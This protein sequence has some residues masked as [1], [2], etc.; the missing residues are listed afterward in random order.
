LVVRIIRVL[1]LF[2]AVLLLAR[3]ARAEHR[4]DDNVQQAR[5][6]F[7]AG[8]RAYAD[9]DYEQALAEFQAGYDLEPRAGFLLNMGHAARKMGK[10]RKARGYYK[11]FLL[12][13]PPEAERTAAETAV[14]DI[15]HELAPDG[16]AAGAAATTAPGANLT[17]AAGAPPPSSSPSGHFYTR[18]W[19]WGAVGAAVTAG[20]VVGLAAGR[21]GGAH[22]SGSWGQLNL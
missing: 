6:H 21:G 13:D 3:P 14:A 2:V 11:Q 22:D 16:D 18:W 12:S 4:A 20:V 7:Q 15:D 17:A 10:L 9:Q 19:F 8:K 5:E 1:P